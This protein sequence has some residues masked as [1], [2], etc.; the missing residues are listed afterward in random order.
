[1][2]TVRQNIADATPPGSVAADATSL[3]VAANETHCA[4]AF[5][6]GIAS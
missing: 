2:P 3:I 4:D 5:Q 1:M 6:S